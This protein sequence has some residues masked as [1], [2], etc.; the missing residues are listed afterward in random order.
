MKLRCSNQRNHGL[1][2]VEVLVVVVLVAIL[3]AMILPA[4][5]AAKRGG[6]PV[7][8]G[9]LRQIGLANQMWAGDNFNKYPAEVSLTNGGAMELASAGN[10]AAFFQVMSNEL[11]TPRVLLCPKDV[12]HVRSDYFH[13]N[14]TAKNISYFIGLNVATNFPNSIIA[15]DSNL[16]QGGHPL[17]PGVHELTPNIMSVWSA[18]RHNRSGNLLLED[19]SVQWLAN[20]NLVRHFQQT[21][22]ATNRLA[23]P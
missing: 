6:G 17:T 18:T 23:I 10:V 22:L 16:E 12:E 13:T 20:S 7:C 14:F 15:G 9:N 3:A 5:T 4:L 21:G 2:L 1:T 8:Y 11:S 19:G